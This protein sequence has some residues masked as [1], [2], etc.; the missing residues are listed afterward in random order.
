LAGGVAE[1]VE[2]DADVAALAGEETDQ[3]ADVLG[4]ARYLTWRNGDASNEPPSRSE[5]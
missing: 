2:I 3:A 4:E 5:K 1:P